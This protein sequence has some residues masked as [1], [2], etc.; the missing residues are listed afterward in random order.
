MDIVLAPDVFV[1]A[2]V[3]V[4]T[5]PEAVVQRVLGKHKGE[6][7]CSQWVLDRVGQM[8]TALPEFKP[9]AVEAQIQLIRGLVQMVELPE[10]FGAGAWEA[11]MVATAKK[12]GVKRVVTDHPDLLEKETSDGVEF[13]A[14][15]AW[16]I[17][18]TTPPP[19]PGG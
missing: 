19:P 15:E 5:P 14:S 18:V 10:D 4:G 9:D 12:A 2:S 7:R 6:S 1:N 11:A 16:L 8:L 3:A 13:V 17:E